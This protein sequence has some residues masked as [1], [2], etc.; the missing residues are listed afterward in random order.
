MYRILLVG[1]ISLVTVVGCGES[2]ENNS[3]AEFTECV[4]LTKG[5]SVVSGTIDFKEAIDVALISTVRV[6][7]YD[8]SIA[9]APNILIAKTCISDVSVLPVVF[10]I[11]YDSKDIDTRNLYTIRAVVY[12]FEENGEEIST[13]RTTQT[14]PVITNGFGHET[15]IL[16]NEI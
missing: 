15:N 12:G 13:H 2:N 8:Y 16:V 1:L 4:S 6:S 5:D 7:L 3:G 11:P 9:D 14:F 10:S